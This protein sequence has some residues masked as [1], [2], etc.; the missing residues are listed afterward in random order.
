MELNTLTCHVA[1]PLVV[2]HFP[3]VGLIMAFYRKAVWFYK[4]WKDYTQDGYLDAEK[5]FDPGD[6][7]GDLKGK[8]FM[9]TGQ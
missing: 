7:D 3:Q 6:L 1:Q 8:S 9:I 4:G 5:K 2:I